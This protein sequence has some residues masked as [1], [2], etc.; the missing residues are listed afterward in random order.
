[1]SFEVVGY[2]IRF[3]SEVVMFLCSKYIS[4]INE[5]NQLFFDAYMEMVVPEI[6]N[7]PWKIIVI[8]PT[9]NRKGKDKD[10]GESMSNKKGALLMYNKKL[11]FDLE[12]KQKQRDNRP[13]KAFNAVGSETLL[14]NSTKTRV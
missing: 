3:N 2:N 1:M 10:V 6:S 7:F 5:Y 9:I 8:A 12:L 14:K 13:R 4:E 11:F